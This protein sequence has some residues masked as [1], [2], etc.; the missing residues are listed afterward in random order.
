MATVTSTT[1]GPPQRARWLLAVLLGAMFLGNV[2]TAVTNTATPAIQSGLGASGAELQLIV[3]GYVLAYAMLLVTSARLGQAHGYRS[4]FLLGLSLFTVTSA[5]CGLAPTALVLVLARVVQ[6][7]AAAL[8]VAQVLSGIQLQYSGRERARALGW[9]AAVLAGSAVFGQVLGGLVITADL[10]GVTWRPI[11]LINVPLGAALVVAALRVLPDDEHGEA[12]SLDAWGV[13]SLS[14]AL[15]LFVVPL[16]LGPGSSWPGWTWAA[17]AG[18]VLATAAFLVIERRVVVA[19]RRPLIDLQLIRRPVIHWALSTAALSTG[20]YFAILFVLALYLQQGLGHTPAYSGLVLVSWVAAF[21]V[22]GPVLG[23]VSTRL[24][25]FAAP[26]GALVLAAGFTGIAASVHAGSTN[27]AALV[28]LLGVGGLGYGAVFSGTLNHLTSAVTDR[29][30]ADIS[31]LFNTAAR[32]GGV[33]G[34]AAFGTLY[35]TLAPTH[36]RQAAVDAFT[37]TTAA[38]ALCAVATAITASLAIRHRASRLCNSGR[39]SRLHA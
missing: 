14:A 17:L 35:L 39:E 2:D 9:Y 24:S 11:F 25:L 38:L 15:L 21:G 6:G 12:Q 22:A 34:V 16:I 32:V 26:A 20:V 8:M 27:T 13:I 37:I 19:G 36:E 29:Y 4:M 33:M 10:F 30:A 18:A 31:G 3:S 7:A 28:A 23:R 5:V 1:T